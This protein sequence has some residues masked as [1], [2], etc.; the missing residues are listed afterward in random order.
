MD[1]TT[2]AEPDY[3]LKDLRINSYGKLPKQSDAIENSIFALMRH[4]HR[5]GVRTAKA[6][7]SMTALAAERDALRDALSGLLKR[8]TALHIRVK[9]VEPC[10]RHLGRTEAAHVH[11]VLSFVEHLR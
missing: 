10:T 4:A 2:A 3:S 8:H 5:L 9:V 7:S 11:M 1:T 6:Q